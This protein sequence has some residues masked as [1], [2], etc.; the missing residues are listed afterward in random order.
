MNNN[1][2]IINVQGE[3]NQVSSI[4]DHKDYLT[5]TKA[6]TVLGFSAA[7]VKVHC[8]LMISH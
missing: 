5:V 6:L 2:N 7:E 4:N 1:M 3:C 8:T